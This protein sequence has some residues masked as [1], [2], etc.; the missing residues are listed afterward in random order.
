MTREQFFTGFVGTALA[1]SFILA[2]AWA[3]KPPLE[4]APGTVVLGYDATHEIAIKGTVEGIVEARSTEDIS[5]AHLF[6][7]TAQGTVDAHLG[8]SSAW[9]PQSMT[10]A[11]GN[12]VELTGVFVNFNGKS[13]LLART[14]KSGNLIIVLRNEHGFLA[15]ADGPRGPLAPAAA[16]GARP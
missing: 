2:V 11:P 16:K 14:L 6:V 7:T 3:Q 13:V 4:T 8:P 15:H 9:E 5:G 10:L 1:G 12:A